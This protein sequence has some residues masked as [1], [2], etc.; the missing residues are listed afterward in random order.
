MPAIWFTSLLS[1]NVGIEVGQFVIV[2]LVFPVLLYIKKLH[3]FKWVLPGN[4]PQSLQWAWLGS[5]N[6]RFN[7][8]KHQELKGCV[9]FY[10]EEYSLGNASNLEL[11]E[12][13]LLRIPSYV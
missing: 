5:F 6:V 10:N 1:F 11:Y 12:A 7:T 13:G 4:L 2:S 8:N 3:S 9:L